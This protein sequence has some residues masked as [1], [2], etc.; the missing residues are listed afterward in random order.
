MI[1]G[2]KSILI[3]AAIILLIICWLPLLAIRRLF[4]F[5]PA[6]YK[7]G[8]LFRKLGKAVSKVNPNW[9]IVIS[10][11]TDIDDRHPY[12]MVCNHLSQADIPLISNLPWEMKWV[13]KEELFKVP[14]S[15]WMMRLAGD[16]SV[17]RKSLMRKRTTLSKGSDYLNKNC[18]VIFFPEG[19]RS[20]TGK[21]HKFT[22]GAFEL[23]I[24]NGVPVLPLV[25]D[26]TQ[27]CLPKK[28]WKFGVA[29]DIRLKVLD[30]VKTEHLSSN[31]IE[32]LTKAVRS[33]IL[34]QLSDWRDEPA[35]EI[36][37]MAKD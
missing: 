31:D 32:D 16:I 10:G 23:A 21:L 12:V 9:Q 1:D 34:Q 4:D 7:T 26:G 14:F 28:S 11:N 20:R 37:Y 3:W 29:Q 18:S 35:S 5:D 8:R 6:R 25:I 24:R 30:P 36:D 27:D 2:I 22:M 33:K 19:T 15:G 13:A 17:D